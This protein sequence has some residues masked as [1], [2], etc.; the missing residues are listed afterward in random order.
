MD[1]P[2]L[3]KDPQIRYFM[4]QELTMALMSN[5]LWAPKTLDEYGLRQWTREFMS[6]MESGT[7]ESL[8]VAMG[9]HFERG[10][11]AAQNLVNTEFNRY[12]MMG[13]CCLAMEL[14]EHVEV[15]LAEPVAE[16]SHA[17]EK[18]RKS[19]E[20][21][22]NMVGKKFNPE[23]LLDHLRKNDYSPFSKYGRLGLNRSP[24]SIRL[25]TSAIRCA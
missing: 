16:V 13:V 17:D 3:D 23:G 7:P 19:Y 2:Y 25:E 12:Y 15:I 18:K 22:M 6:A 20:K 9:D 11:Q 5:T 10:Q 4:R 1:F 8:L 24:L 21:L 14:D